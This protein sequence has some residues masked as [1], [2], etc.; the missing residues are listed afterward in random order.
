M[1]STK[2]N[3]LEYLIAQKS[4]GTELK[5][6]LD[7]TTGADLLPYDLE[8]T[9][10]EEL[11]KIQPLAVLMDVIPAGGLT[12]E[13]RLRTSHPQAWFEGE[14]TPANAKNS[15]YT[16]KTVQ[17]KIQRIWG[18]VTGFEQSMSEA[19]IDALATE[20]S[21][22]V[23]GMSNILEYGLMWGA[24]DDIGFT[25]DPYQY[26]GV[27]PR[28]MALAP[29]NIVDGAGAKV[30]LDMLDQAIAK[31][32]FRG[33]RGDP[34]LWVMGSRMRQIVDSLQTQV[35]IPLTSVE[36][37]DGKIRMAAYDGI[38]ILE[39][40]FIVPEA[41]TTS[42]TVTA[43]IADGGALAD[44]EYFYVISSVTVTGE[45]VAGT[46]DSATTSTTNN[47]VD[48]TWTADANAV[49]YMI[50]RGLATGNDNLQLLDIIPALT[51]DAA[52]T[53]NGSVETYTDDGS[54]T[55]VDVRP[56]SDGEHNIL[57]INRNPARGAAFIGKVDSMGRPID[58]LFSYVELARVKDTYDYMLKG[59]L[60]ARLVYP[61]LISIEQ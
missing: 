57:L 52:G 31:T 27:I 7:T 1:A 28:L 23:E 50:F 10:H 61:N 12:H 46:E 30:D 55:A 53:V 51:Y 21:G 38:G 17:T 24:A 60:A 36:L 44:D 35:S 22:S 42:P 39:S 41:T 14:T 19:F 4:Q 47:S 40:D 15:T 59:Y 25:G 5:K 13:Y 48:L 54:L 20:L 32:N 18:S 26:S 43:T 11:L 16:R 34:R 33:V 49:A 3:I 6:A 37:A 2:R 58:R 29:S 8:P 45:Q 9:L 56:L